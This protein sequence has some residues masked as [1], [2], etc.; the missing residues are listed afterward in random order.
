MVFCYYR[1]YGATLQLLSLYQEPPDN[2]R[3][4]KQVAWHREMLA[5]KLSLTM[6][7]QKE[8]HHRLLLLT[9]E[10]AA[11]RKLLNFL[12]EYV[13]ETNSCEDYEL[14]WVSA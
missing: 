1:A 7:N 3:S 14:L 2:E 8:A 4:S 13:N 11:N 5:G 10:L 9:E 6:G 12:Q